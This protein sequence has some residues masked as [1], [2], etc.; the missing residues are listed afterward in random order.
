MMVINQAQIRGL[1]DRM[2]NK[3]AQIEGLE[4]RMADRDVQIAEHQAEIATLLDHVN[5][6]TTDAEGIMILGIDLS[7]SIAEIS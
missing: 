4:A 2:T 6:L 5:I 1:E 7:M 3:D